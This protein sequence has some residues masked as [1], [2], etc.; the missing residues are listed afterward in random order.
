MVGEFVAGDMGEV[1]A[2]SGGDESMRLVG[3]VQGGR[4][5]VADSGSRRWRPCNEERG[6][7]I[8][9]YIVIEL[10]YKYGSRHESQDAKMS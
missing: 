9:V 3:G 2:L 10:G 5:R 1:Q 4:R 6:R 8:R 7:K